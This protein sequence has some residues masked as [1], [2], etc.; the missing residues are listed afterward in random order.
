[1]KNKIL[2]FLALIL[3]PSCTNFQSVQ[4]SQT[5]IPSPSVTSQPS[6]TPSPT[7]TETSIPTSTFTTTPTV[8][9]RSSN[10]TIVATSASCST[11]LPD[12]V[13]VSALNIIISGRILKNYEVFI[14]WPGFSGSSFLCPQQATLVSFGENLAPVICS[15]KGITLVSVGLTELTITIKWEG[16]SYTQTLYPNYEAIFPQGPDCEPQCSIGKS[17]IK[18]P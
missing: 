2:I 4:P 3:M 9:F 6:L 7:S 1:M 12:K 8:Q 16:G 17:E 10:P 18:I 15:G 11:G 14:T 13:C 5:S